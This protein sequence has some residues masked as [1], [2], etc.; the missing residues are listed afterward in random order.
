MGAAQT[1]TTATL[2]LL[3]VALGRLASDIVPPA[4]VTADEGAARAARDPALV[5]NIV[6]HLRLH[7]QAQVTDDRG[8]LRPLSR[9]EAERIAH[10]T[11]RATAAWLAPGG[12][13]GR[14]TP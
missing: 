10:V 7:P 9:E 5:D 2:A 14:P 6:R 1:D 11:L 8:R 4:A 13:P 3:G 12:E